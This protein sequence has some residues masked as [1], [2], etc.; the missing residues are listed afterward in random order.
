MGSDVARRFTQATEE[1]TAHPPEFF[2]QNTAGL[3]FRRIAHTVC[4]QYICYD[5]DLIYISG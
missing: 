4:A 3:D 5:F 2:E 1:L